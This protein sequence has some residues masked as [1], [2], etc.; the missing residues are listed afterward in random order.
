LRMSSDSKLVSSI[1]EHCPGTQSEF[2][3]KSN[4]CSGCPNQQI[5]SSKP[6]LPDPDLDAISERM[7][8]VKHK[9]IVLSGKGGVGKSTFSS[10]LSF[11]LSKLGAQVGLMDIDICGPSIPKLLGLEGEQIHQSNMGWSPVYIEENLGVMSVGFMLN[12]PN[13]AVIWRGPKKNTL[14]K[15]FLKDVYWGDLDYLVIDTPPG[16]SDEHLSINQYLKLSGSDGAIVITTPQ[17]VSLLDV[18]KEINFCRKVGLP[19]I[20]IVENMSGFIC[21]KC[22]TETKIFAPTTGGAEKMAKDMVIQFLGSIPLDPQIARACDEGRFY[23][24]DFPDS[25]ATHAFN[26]IFNLVMK[27][28]NSSLQEQ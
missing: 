27:A 11:A 5:C 6:K 16:T 18:R 19:I 28:I 9:L 4:A 15:Q 8:S 17:E 24:S 7:S 22:H 23:L 20:G 12:D 26:S 10:Q 3:G 25:L 21:P 1:P 2:A 14:I 13:E